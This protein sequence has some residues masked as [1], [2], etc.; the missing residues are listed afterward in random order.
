M[1]AVLLVSLSNHKHEASFQKKKAHPSHKAQGIAGGPGHDSA[2][3]ADV[4]H[5]AKRRP[6]GSGNRPQEQDPDP[7]IAPSVVLYLGAFV[8][9]GYSFWGGFNGKPKDAIYFG[10]PPRISSRQ[11]HGRNMPK[12]ASTRWPRTSSKACGENTGKLPGSFGWKKCTN[13]Q[14]PEKASL[15][16]LAMGQKPN[17]TPSP[18][19]C[20]YPKMVP[21]VLTHSQVSK[22]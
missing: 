19:W 3:V 15:S 20:T 10:G 17:R 1:V 7:F 11:P 8:F 16:P 12:A 21:L 22:S 2:D 13:G 9:R 14:F 6:L 4:G 5:L 18:R